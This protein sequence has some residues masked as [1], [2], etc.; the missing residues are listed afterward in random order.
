MTESDLTWP[1]KSRFSYSSTIRHLVLFYILAVKKNNDIFLIPE[2]W[3]CLPY[4][5]SDKLQFGSL[6]FPPHTVSKRNRK[7]GNLTFILYRDTENNT[8]ETVFVEVI[9][10]MMRRMVE[11]FREILELL[12]KFCGHGVI[13]AEE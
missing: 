12:S 13:Y 3:Y 8:D 6:F 10:A 5:G 11:Q 9:G 2:F 7:V 1:I 4:H